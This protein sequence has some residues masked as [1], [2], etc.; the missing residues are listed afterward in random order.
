MS[1]FNREF[2]IDDLI[3]ISSA[4]LVVADFS[5][6]RESLINLNKTIYGN[7]IDMSGESPD[8]QYITSIALIINNIL[9]LTQY[10]YKNI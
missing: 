4:G 10:A 1:I 7:D 2:Q 5:K 6:I 3:N 8:V 9:Q